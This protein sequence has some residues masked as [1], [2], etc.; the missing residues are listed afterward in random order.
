MAIS[1]A[2]EGGKSINVTIDATANPVNAYAAGIKEAFRTKISTVVQADG[3]LVASSDIVS[4][5]SSGKGSYTLE[6][7]SSF[8]FDSQNGIFITSGWLAMTGDAVLEVSRGMKDGITPQHKGGATSQESAGYAEIHL[9]REGG[10]VYA[11]AGEGAVGRIAIRDNA[12]VA[13]ANQKFIFDN[14]VSGTLA[15][16]SRYSIGN[17]EVTQDMASKTMVYSDITGYLEQFDYGMLAQRVLS[18]KSPLGFA[19]WAAG[20]ADSPELRNLSDA[21][22]GILRSAA[23]QYMNEARPGNYTE[24]AA[25]FFKAI[26]QSGI[27]YTTQEV[28]TAPGTG[29]AVYGS[30]VRHSLMTTLLE[31][32]GLTTEKLREAFVRK[33]FTKETSGTAENPTPV[34][35]LRDADMVQQACAKVWASVSEF[36]QIYNKYAKEAISSMG[37][38]GFREFVEG[39]PDSGIFS[40]LDQAGRDLLRSAAAEYRT[41]A[42]TGKYEEA[43]SQ[44]FRTIDQSGLQYTFIERQSS[45]YEIGS[46]RIDAEITEVTR[47]LPIMSGVLESA[48]I[49]KLTLSLESPGIEAKGR[50]L[51]GDFNKAYKAQDIGAMLGVIET[52]QKWNIAVSGAQM[53]VSG[54]LDR[55]TVGLKMGDLPDV[56]KS[57]DVAF[58]YAD[59]FFNKIQSGAT[60]LTGSYDISTWLQNASSMQRFK[61][62]G[63]DINMRSG[64]GYQIASVFAGQPIEKVGG[65]G[66]EGLYWAGAKSVAAGLVF[67]ALAVPTGFSASA[68]IFYAAWTSL[69]WATLSVAI[70]VAVKTLNGQDITAGELIGTF[71]NTAGTA[72]MFQ[73]ALAGATGAYGIFTKA[74]TAVAVTVAEETVRTGWVSTNTLSAL[75]NVAAALNR[76]S[77]IAGRVMA[78]A[79]SGAVI[80]AARYVVHDVILKGQDFTFGGLA[81][82]AGIGFLVGAGAGLAGGLLGGV[83]ALSSLTA[84]TSVIAQ[85]AVLTARTITAGLIS[86]TTGAIYNGGFDWKSAIA[87]FAIGAGISLAMSFVR[88]GSHVNQATIEVGK[89]AT[90]QFTFSNFTALRHAMYVGSS[91]WT[92]AAKT[93]A[94][95][96]ALMIIGAAAKVGFD[97]ARFSMG[98]LK[99]Q[100]GSR[101]TEFTPRMF[102]VSAFNGAVMG[103]VLAIMGSSRGLDLAGAAGRNLSRYGQGENLAL[104][105]ATSKADWLTRMLVN[106]FGVKSVTGAGLIGMD[107][108]RGAVSWIAVSPAFSAFTGMFVWVRDVVAGSVAGFIGEDGK[109]FTLDGLAQG[110]KEAWSKQVMIRNDITQKDISLTQGGFG[111]VMTAL[112]TSAIMGPMQGMYMGPLIKMFSVATTPGLDTAYGRIRVAMSRAPDPLTKFLNAAQARWLPSEAGAFESKLITNRVYGLLGP[113]APLAQWTAGNFTMAGYVTAVNT[114]LSLGAQVDEHGKFINPTGFGSWLVSPDG[115][116]I[117]ALGWFFLFV[118]AHS[119]YTRAE[120]AAVTEAP[121]RR[122]APQQAKELANKQTEILLSPE[123]RSRIH[124]LDHDTS[125]DSR[126]KKMNREVIALDAM[127]KAAHELGISNPFAIEVIAKRYSGEAR[128]TQLAN[129][130]N[131]GLK[132]VKAGRTAEATASVESLQISRENLKTLVDAIQKSVDISRESGAA[133]PNIEAARGNLSES[134]GCKISRGGDRDTYD[135]PSDRDS[136]TSCGVCHRKYKWKGRFR[137]SGSFDA[138]YVMRRR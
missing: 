97:Y 10:Q 62:M 19:D 76:V 132:D 72:F 73:M 120:Q 136:S 34:Y 7:G 45:Y 98:G 101:I 106:T 3:S 116:G 9:R 54:T 27:T 86:A 36:G 90:M 49:G 134:V 11:Y 89:D 109:R 135:K 125:M 79:V 5:T 47:S 82:N 113:I 55:T 128:Q 59:F 96:V 22:R 16:G 91:A 94:V 61:E 99:D 127:A 53:M 71:L 70:T 68:V 78:S 29:M 35:K 52:A 104:T 107:M 75:E 87:D 108:V 100:N 85:A 64:L 25:G 39:L 8:K 14:D 83:K 43:A 28:T 4:A 133:T 1:E 92:T 80:G 38:D 40:T 17:S 63:L 60:P 130:I 122:A 137:C 24:A 84:S 131:E 18:D 20:L 112:L 111:N 50:A 56:S 30:G 51:D 118:K 57:A 124:Q 129:I 115:A 102:A 126:S 44:F 42:Q 6:K 13:T 15:D 2:A 12:A 66:L 74:P 41:N 23:A 65:Q 32:M 21:D 58:A 67:L 77:Q 88:W 95:T 31:G 105:V 103:L 138:G 121:L 33:D 117:G 46:S 48:D 26:D 119:G 123:F 81:A 69:V 114:I 37:A 93:L 110:F